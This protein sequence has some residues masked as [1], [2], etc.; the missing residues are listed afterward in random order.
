[1]KILTFHWSPVAGL[2]QSLPRAAGCR[3]RGPKAIPRARGRAQTV[4]PSFNA[5][6]S[7]TKRFALVSLLSAVSAGLLVLLL[8]GCTAPI[9]ADRV[10]TRQAY[11]QMEE[12]AL[13]TAKLSATTVAILHRFDLDHLAAR[14]PAE[15]VR[16]LHQ[17]A[18]A[19]GERDLLFAL[20][21]LSYAAGEQIGRSVKPW[22][23]RDARDY[24]LGAAVYAWLF[25]FAEPEGAPPGFLDRRLGESCAFYNYGLGLALTERRSSDATVRLESGRRRL[26]VGAI[27]LKL[28]L[29]H[30]PA[31]LDDF[32][33]FLL[34]DQFRVRGLSVRTREPGVGAPLLAVQRCDPELGV[35]RCSPATVFLRLPHSLAEVDA[36][37]NT[38][39]LELYSAFDNTTLTIG[40]FQVPL[41]T[42]CTTH[43][44]YVLNQS[45][46]WG[47]GLKQFLMPARTVRSQLIPLQPFSPSRIPVV[48]VHGTFSSPVTWAELNNTL[49]ADPVLRQRYQIW[50]F[51]YGSGN[52]LPV[53]AGELRDA[54]T[55]AV[56][57]LD[58]ENTNA[59]LRQMVVIGHSQGGLL[60]K[61]TA[62]ATGD[63]LWR[64]LSDKPM[65]DL[66]IAEDQRARLR[67]LLVLEPLPFVRR[68]VFISTPH[69]GSYLASSFA[70]R[71]A[72][73]LMSLPS[74]TVSATRDM[75]SL[76]HGSKAEKFL[77]GR[78]PTS[79]D[80]MSPKNPGLLALADIP[81]APWITAHSI[82]PVL[83]ESDYRQ[84]RD[85]VV[86]YQSAHVDYV[87]SELVV[88]G[89]H[90]C[91]RLPATIEEV[92]RILHEHLQSVETTLAQSDFSGSLKLGA[93][94][95]TQ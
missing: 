80:G 74:A 60:T 82:I 83:G 28:N 90:S 55:A 81:V 11:A 39:S 62:T 65:K 58:P 89:K 47:L 35:R 93:R 78:M 44:A 6:H 52:S 8:A 1:M 32:E 26:P 13:R 59:L 75:A 63:K 42:D 94:L 25:L 9:G 34:A 7:R 18:L 84:G 27:D 76:A 41:E 24:Y 3:I 70:R 29:T 17:R 66:S 50:S 68:V 91:L 69:R 72:S 37:T 53:S 4:S 20:A 40:R 77:R 30:F 16:Q 31:T 51:V 36:A 67:R 61:L 23:P 15:A 10:T 21:E 2:G 88:R 54:L 86:T 12:N 43:A 57:K 46:V 5:S 56:A 49:A 48:F 87:E 92:R 73:R 19:T 85:G 45:A 33:Q 71:F 79:L 38:A 22:D 64:A 14:Q 95:K